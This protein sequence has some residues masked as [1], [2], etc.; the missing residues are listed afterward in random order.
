[1]TLLKYTVCGVLLVASTAMAGHRRHRTY[2]AGEVV[3]AYWVAAPYAYVAAA[4][5][6]QPA[7]A[8]A[9]APVYQPAPVVVTE[10]PAPVQQTVVYAES[11]RSD[12]DTC[13]P[14][15]VKCGKAK[16]EE[17]KGKGCCTP[18]GLSGCIRY[19]VETEYIAPG[20]LDLVLEFSHRGQ[21]LTDEQGRP[22]TVVVPLDDPSDVD[23]EEIEYKGSVPTPLPSGPW[24]EDLRIHGQVVNRGTNTV[25]DRGKGE[26]ELPEIDD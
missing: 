18:E 22:I 4:P 13:R 26:L 6:Y 12:C 3:G 25:L 17:L 23:D 10:A 14:C 8:V 19:E 5:V 9:V 1:M 7:P 2:V 20:Q 11:R 21:K 16:I 24:C 15:K